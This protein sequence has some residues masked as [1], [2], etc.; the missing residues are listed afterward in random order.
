MK[1]DHQI[2]MK[3]VPTILIYFQTI[4][5]PG[6]AVYGAIADYNLKCSGTFERLRVQFSAKISIE[7][8]QVVSLSNSQSVTVIYRGCEFAA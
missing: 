8:I 3:W 1:S 5:C 6:F 4:F 7:K 2:L